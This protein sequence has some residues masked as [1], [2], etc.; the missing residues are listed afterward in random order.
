MVTFRLADSLPNIVVKGI[1]ASS[2]KDSDQR[3][4]M[5][6]Y[7]D[8]SHGAC[9]LRD[10]LIARL[11]ENALLRF[12]GERY[13]LLAWSVMPNH[14]HVLVELLPD[15]TLAKALHSWKSFTAHG[16]NRL[17]DRSGSFWQ[18]EYWDRYIR[19]EEHFAN[20]VRY[21]HGNRSDFS[22]GSVGVA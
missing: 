3:E 16:A 7:L 6:A 8:A 11:V 17:L 5:E 10:P 2:R 13:R 9:Y 14:V 12:D 21:I 1:L 19:D 4:R 15:H 20:A 22:S 18:R